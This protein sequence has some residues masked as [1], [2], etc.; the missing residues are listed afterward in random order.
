MLT[1]QD[2]I[3]FSGL[4][5]DQLD[6]IAHHKHLPQVI[7]AEWAETV[8]DRSDGAQIVEAALVEEVDFACAHGDARCAERYRR[9][10][11]DFRRQHIAH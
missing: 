8:L 7:A 6:A 11:E 9:G 1:L 4:T 3:A 2:C 10:L 5:S